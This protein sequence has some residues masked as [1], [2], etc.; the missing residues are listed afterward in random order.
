MPFAM[1]RIDMPAWA[2]ARARDA[3]PP[4]DGPFTQ[5]LYR[6]VQARRAEF[7]AAV[8][9]AVEE[10]LCPLDH[11][12]PQRSVLTGE[13]YLSGRESYSFR[14][15]AG[16]A[17]VILKARCLGRDDELRTPG[18]PDDYCGIDVSVEYDPAT[19]SFDAEGFSLQVLWSD[20][21]LGLATDAEPTAAA[22]GG[23]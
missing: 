5:E 2:N 15:G 14:G 9:R 16:R 3:E 20:R 22:D 21:A 17:Q 7:L 10:H 18:Q 4:P 6:L 11:A 12:F 23:A 13:Y 8:H 19:D 1:R